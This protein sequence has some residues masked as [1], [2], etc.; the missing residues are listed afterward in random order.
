MITK[1]NSIIL[2][3]ILAIILFILVNNRN[4]II[5]NG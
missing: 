3:I 2:S 5:I 1:I 4:N